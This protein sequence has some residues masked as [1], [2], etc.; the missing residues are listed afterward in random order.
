MS[1]LV[2]NF[3]S[4]QMSNLVSSLVSYWVGKLEKIN[5]LAGWQVST[6]FKPNTVLQFWWRS[7][8]YGF[9]KIY[10]AARGSAGCT[11]HATDES[12]VW[13]R[14]TVCDQ[15]NCMGTRYLRTNSWRTHGGGYVST[16]DTRLSR[17]SVR[18]NPLQQQQHDRLCSLTLAST[19][20]IT[21]QMRR[22]S[23]P[24]PST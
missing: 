7:K 1:K 9:H 10:H 8:G 6:R 5:K 18:W 21:A 20:D 12:L 17:I 19:H 22:R 4:Y 16:S 15:F 3:V 11:L 23:P 2:S 24:H 14:A 13:M